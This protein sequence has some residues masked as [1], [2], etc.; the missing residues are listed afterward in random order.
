MARRLCEAGA[1]VVIVDASAPMRD[2]KIY[3][4]W[5]DHANASNTGWDLKK[6]MELRAGYLDQA[7]T[8]LI[9]DVYDRG[10]DQRVMIAALGEFGRSPHMEQA[11]GCT[12]RS[13]WPGAF[14]ALLSGGGIRTGQVIGDTDASAGEPVERPLTPQD[15]HATF[16]RHLGIDPSTAFEDLTG[17]PI[18]ILSSGEPIRELF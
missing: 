1:G 4:S 3:W 8:A 13:H 11:A 5:D 16:Y 2:A 6:G 10:L 7:L 14:S 12:G 18:P 17:R 9:Q 15:L